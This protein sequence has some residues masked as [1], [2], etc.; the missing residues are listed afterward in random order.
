MQVSET[1][2]EFLES[3]DRT[4]VLATANAEGRVNAAVFGS[5][6]LVDGDKIRLML[7]DNRTYDNLNQNP[8]AALFVSIHGKAGMAMEGCRLYLKMLDTADAGPEFEAVHAEIKKRIGDAASM[9]KHLVKLE[10]VETRPILDF[11]QGV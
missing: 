3:P 4:N 11:G 7:G 6:M 5:P 8:F 9:L 2:A 10:V 1:V